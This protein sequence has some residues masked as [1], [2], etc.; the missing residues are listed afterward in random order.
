[1]KQSPSEEMYSYSPQKGTVGHCYAAQ[2]F[3]EG[4]AFIMIEPTINEE[5]ASNTAKRITSLL[6]SKV[7]SPSEEGKFDPHLVC[8]PAHK[9]RNLKKLVE[10]VRA[11]K[12]EDKEDA[13]LLSNLLAVLHGDGGHYEEKH[14]TKKAVEDA[15]DK[16]Y[17]LHTQID[18]L[19]KRDQEDSI[20]WSKGWQAAA[21]YYLDK[22]DECPK[23][24]YTKE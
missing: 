10:K 16:Y 11:L 13:H 15:I 19:K 18:E 20:I 5:E 7:E 17:S 9:K 4:K 22:P 21:H 14:G 8:V 2:V 1:M 23:N 6:N 3:K 12:Q 24:P